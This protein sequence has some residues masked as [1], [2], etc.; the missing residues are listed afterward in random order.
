[1]CKILLLLLFWGGV[2][3]QQAPV[4]DRAKVKIVV[5][6]S[7]GSPIKQDVRVHVKNETISRE[8]LLQT[9]GFVELPFGT[10]TIQCTATSYR[11]AVRTITFQ[12]AEEQA[13]FALAVRTPEQL[14]GEGPLPAWKVR[15]KIELM[16]YSPP[17]LVRLVG[18]FSEVSQE[19]EVDRTGAFSFVVSDQGKYLLLALEGGVVA[20][21][22]ELTVDVTVPDEIELGVLPIRPANRK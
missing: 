5:V 16:T 10:Y 1:M 8:L 20:Y 18:L 9:R 12:R 14:I 15:G 19:A 6:D 7:F 22:R 17:V 21:E 13:V 2:L 11:S 3:G 4:R